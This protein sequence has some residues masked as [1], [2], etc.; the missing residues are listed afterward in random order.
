MKEGHHPG[1][2][3]FLNVDPQ[4]IDINIHPTKTEIKFEDEQ[5]LYAILRATIKHS[6]G[7]FN[8]SPV[9]DFNRDANLDTPYSYNQKE[10]KIPGI[11]INKNFNPFIEDIKTSSKRSQ[12]TTGSNSSWDSLY[13]GLG[14]K[15]AHELID[16][17][18]IEMESEDPNEQLFDPSTTKNTKKTLQL[19]NKYI[20]STIKNG[21]LLIHRQ[22][23][24]ERILYEE[25]LR[26]ITV[27]EGLSQQ[28]LF[29]LTLE[30]SKAELLS[31][32]NIK[33]PLESMGF[34]F[35]SFSETAIE[36]CGIPTQVSET[37][38]TE[39]FE[40]LLADLQN[41]MP[42]AILSQGDAL[43]RSMAKNLAIKSGMSS[44]GEADE[45]LI[46]QLFGCKEPNTSPTNKTVFITLGL[47][48][49][50]KKFM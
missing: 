43:A 37:S 7:Q 5:A 48:E 44:N 23:A 27:K 34:I 18:E 16:I 17:N 26:Y 13:V 50:D 20:I 41:E 29:P 49:L 3:L 24:H 39:L 19:K 10:V 28:L 11:E 2:F 36:L 12:T 8:V 6:L 45:Q 30:F 4:S 35:K 47:D 21:V 46:N 40:S 22:R 42:D 33:E 14:N 9:L 38:I 25:L 31:L 1:Y 15:D 32:N